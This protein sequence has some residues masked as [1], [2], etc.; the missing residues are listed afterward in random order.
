MK[1]ITIQI[2]LVFI[3]AVTACNITPNSENTDTPGSPPVLT[4]SQSLNTDKAFLNITFTPGDSESSVKGDLTLPGSGP[5]GTSIAWSSSNPSVVEVDGTVTPVLGSSEAVTLIATITKG[6]ESDTKE[7][8][9][10]VQAATCAGIGGQCATVNSC[11]SC[12]GPTARVCI[13]LCCTKVY[14]PSGY[15]FYSY[16]GC[17]DGYACC[18]MQ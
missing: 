4:D 6:A 9:I 7:F 3:F 18:L 13:A 11:A 15:T 8:T 16:N 2:I 12:C 10:T 17:S 5:N 14:C 1:Q